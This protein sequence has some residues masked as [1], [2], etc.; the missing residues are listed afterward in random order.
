MH[1]IGGKRLILRDI[2]VAIWKTTCLKSECSTE[3]Y[4]EQRRYICS[5]SCL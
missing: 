1:L 2:E 4:E 3:A 5:R